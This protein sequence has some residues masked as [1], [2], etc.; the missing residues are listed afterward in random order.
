MVKWAEKVGTQVTGHPSEEDRSLTK[1]GSEEPG[2][3]N[4]LSRGIRYH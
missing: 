4:F 2:R 1:L 3:E